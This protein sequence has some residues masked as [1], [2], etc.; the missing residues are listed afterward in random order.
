VDI[1]PFDS[2]NLPAHLA[3]FDL[4][5]LS[6]GLGSHVSG[7]FP[8][9]SIKGKVFA[10]VRD[11]E[12]HVLPNPKDPDSP[13][14]SIEVVII[15]TNKE[16]SKVFYAKGYQEGGE[17]IKPDCFSNDGLAP[18]A[19]VENPQAKKCALCPHNQWGAKVGENGKKGKACGDSIRIAVAQPDLIND[20][21]LLRVPAASIKPLREY[22][23][24]VEKRGVAVPML[25]TRI[26]FDMEAPTPK[27]TF[28]G[29][30]FLDAST[31]QAV[32]EAR[33]SDVVANILGVGDNSNHYVEP[34]GDTEPAVAKAAATSKI[35]VSKDKKVKDE[36]VAAA[37]AA[38]ERVTAPEKKSAKADTELSLDD[39]DLD[40]LNFDDL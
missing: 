2:K 13:A 25:L 38:A 6:D 28:K 3:N 9:I 29:M 24:G 26:G 18:D 36:E 17:N 35:E 37:V 15:K 40:D 10:T 7:G 23:S 30:G 5:G 12:R 11:G 16:P 8:I 14:T 33:N 27:L 20:P 31:V 4:K 34:A 22:V 39:I 32:T 1:I 19:S 21:Y